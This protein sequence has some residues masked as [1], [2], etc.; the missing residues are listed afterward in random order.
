[1]VRKSDV[2]VHVYTSYPIADPINP[3]R[4]PHTRHAPWNDAP[5]STEPEPELEPGVAGE[6]CKPP[7]AP[8]RARSVVAPSVLVVRVWGRWGG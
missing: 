1:M 8:R 6:I 3:A 7:L 4:T 2:Y 5:R